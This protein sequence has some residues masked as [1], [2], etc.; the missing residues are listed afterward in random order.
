[1]FAIS[2]LDLKFGLYLAW[3]LGMLML[4]AGELM[5]R[6]SMVLNGALS[7][8]KRTRP[9]LKLNPISWST[10]WS[11]TFLTLLCWVWVLPCNASGQQKNAPGRVRMSRKLVVFDEGDAVLAC[12]PGRAGD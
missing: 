1:M 4:L 6:V 7:C 5:I 3:S 2:A 11:I 9:F 10:R 8:E 12:H